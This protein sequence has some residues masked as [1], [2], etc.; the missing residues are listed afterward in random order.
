[1]IN[2]NISIEQKITYIKAAASFDNAQEA[3]DDLQSVLTYNVSDSSMESVVRDLENS[4]TLIETR[5]W[6]DNEYD[7]YRETRLGGSQNREDSVHTLLNGGW[8]VKEEI[9][10]EV[11]FDN[12]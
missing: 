2:N 10:G 7:D 3:L 6:T 9:D 5:M 1:M 4:T 11:H 8:L 12:T